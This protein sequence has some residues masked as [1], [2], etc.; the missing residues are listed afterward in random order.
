M[1]NSTNDAVRLNGIRWRG[2]ERSTLRISANSGKNTSE[3]LET[4]QN[5]INSPLNTIKVQSF[6]ERT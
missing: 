3:S 4:H 6:P 1:K 5:S 2:E